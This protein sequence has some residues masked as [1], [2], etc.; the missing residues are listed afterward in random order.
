MIDYDCFVAD[1][2]FRAG[3]PLATIR[4][5]KFITEETEDGVIVTSR[6]LGSSLRLVLP[7]N[8]WTKQL[9][10]TFNL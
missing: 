9:R 8:F 2:L 1:L 7:T 3:A 5:R 10:S 6:E 4:L